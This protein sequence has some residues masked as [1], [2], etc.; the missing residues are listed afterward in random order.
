MDY[1][2]KIGETSYNPSVYQGAKNA[3]FTRDMGNIYK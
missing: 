3:T 2:R 1:K